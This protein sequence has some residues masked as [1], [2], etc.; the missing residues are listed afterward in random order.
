MTDGPTIFALSSGRGPAGIAVIRISGPMAGHVLGRMA[1]PR[2]PPRFAAL[3]HVKD[4]VS[5]ERLD[6]ALTLWFPSPRSETGEDMAELQVHGGAAV[7]RSVF[8]A[9]AKIPGCRLAEPGEFARRAFENG[10]IDLTSAEGLADLIDAETEAQRRQALAQAG[11]AF[12]RVC[13]DWR[14]RLL[15]ARALA[16]AAID[17][18]EEAD[19][20]TDAIDRARAAAAALAIELEQYLAGAHRGE[21]V[22]DG[23]RVVLAGPPN[24]GKSSLLNAL[25]RRDVAI[26]SPEAGTT[27]DVIEVRLDLGGY[28]V[29][30]ADTAGLR[31]TTGAIEQ[32]GIRRTYSQ[33]RQADLIIW[34]VDAAEPVWEA[35]PELTNVPDRLLVVV[36]KAD[37][38]SISGPVLTNKWAG[39]SAG[40][41]TSIPGN[42]HAGQAPS[43][44]LVVSALMGIGL[45][46]L[47]DHL[48]ATVASRLAGAESSV[49]PTQA[50]HRTAMV[51]CRDALLR[52]SGAEHPEPELAAEELRLAAD[53]LG[54]ITGRVDQEQLLGRI[55]SRFCIGK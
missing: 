33:A 19:V 14:D 37:L 54:R 45:P 2:P 50:R 25:A 49:I 5:G 16:E 31:D 39:S 28:A 30:V 7:I 9:L 4:P 35:P 29:V 40:A 42:E 22:R 21:I 55:F 26:V 10:R 24:A 23:F 53:S 47:I 3:R 18:S 32:E 8:A 27:R 6:E 1:P 52:L 11:G 48:A 51:D 44:A 12:G 46:A 41:Q 20:V 43:P 13:D 15:E 17:F 38:A 36:N 34:L